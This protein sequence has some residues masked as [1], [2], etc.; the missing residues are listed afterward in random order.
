MRFYYGPSYSQGYDFYPSSSGRSRHS[1]RYRQLDKVKRGY[2]K[3]PS[4]YSWLDGRRKP[5]P[6]KGDFQNL[7]NTTISPAGRSDNLSLE[8]AYALAEQELKGRVRSNFVC[9]TS[10]P[11]R[12][13]TALKMKLPFQVF[14]ELDRECFCSKLQGNVS[15]AWSDLPSGMLSQTTRIGQNG[16]R[17]TR[18]QL[19]PTLY[20]YGSRHDILAA[21]IHQMVHAYYLQRCGYRDRGFSGTGHDLEHDQSFA[22]L[23]KLVGEYLRP[24]QGDLSMELQDP[25]KHYGGHA[26]DRHSS[27]HSIDPTS[28]VSC[29]YGIRTSF[30]DRDI[31]SWHDHAVATAASLQDAR[32]S[33]GGVWGNTGR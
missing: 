16:A 33:K 4:P 14:N 22:G 8:E 32:K 1:D 13:K 18:I 30:S 24:L 19:S 26:S 25:R 7:K 28:G 10:A 9:I 12:M 5:G 21:L 17:R 3:L 2:P 11:R 29:C 20:E 6:S 15:L 23:L 31:R 27:M